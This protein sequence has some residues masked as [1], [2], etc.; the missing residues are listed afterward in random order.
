[1]IARAHYELAQYDAAAKIFAEIRK[2]HPCRTEG[3][4]IYSTCL[5]HL[6][7]EAQLSALAQELVEMDRSDPIAWLVAATASLFTKREKLL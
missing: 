3:M 5:W 7:R 1:M 2:T 4:D 6:Q